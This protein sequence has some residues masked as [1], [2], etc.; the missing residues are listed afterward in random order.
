MH[1]SASEASLSSCSSGGTPPVPPVA[2]SSTY[3]TTPDGWRL[4]L[5]RVAPAGGPTRR[6][7]VILCPGLG[8]SGG[9]SFDLEPGVSMAQYLAEAGFDCW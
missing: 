1:H 3:A 5:A 6:Y 8:S 4:H 7:P 9:P 2:R